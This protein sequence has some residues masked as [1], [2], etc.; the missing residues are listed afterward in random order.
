MVDGIYVYVEKRRRKKVTFS[1]SFFQFFV[2][3]KEIKNA[4]LTSKHRKRYYYEYSKS[5]SKKREK[6]NMKRRDG[7]VAWKM[8]WR[9]GH[10]MERLVRS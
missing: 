3:S 5:S 10:T 4:D 6:N 7:D 8:E 2:Y 1:S 9:D